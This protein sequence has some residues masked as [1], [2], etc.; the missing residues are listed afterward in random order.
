[1][2]R[3][4][5]LIGI[6]GL[7]VGG[8]IGHFLTRAFTEFPMDATVEILTPAESRTK[9]FA[10]GLVVQIVPFDEG[11]SIEDAVDYLRGQART[12]IEIDGMPTPF[13]L[14]FVVADPNHTAKQFKLYLKDI[15][16]DLLCERIAQAAG[17]AVSFDDDAIVFAA[18]PK[19]GE[20]GNHH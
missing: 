8:A 6:A 15:R 20:A 3:R 9:L 18:L 2:N 5:L 17:L 10:K 7:L 1:M 13:R 19:S 16:L 12:G 4:A 14:N 11:V